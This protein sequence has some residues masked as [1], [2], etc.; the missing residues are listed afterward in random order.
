MMIPINNTSPAEIQR[1]IAV[2]VNQIVKD[3]NRMPWHEFLGDMLKDLEQMHARYFASEMAPSGEPWR[4]LS[5][6]T[7]AKK[8]FDRILHDSGRLYNSLGQRGPGAIRRVRH[9][10]LVFGTS[11]PYAKYHMTGFRNVRSN[12]QVPARP[13]LGVTGGDVRELSE[14][15]AEAIVRKL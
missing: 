1:G 7:I 2:A 14:K 3:V 5:P 4:S 10:E 12:T 11:V 13:F 15:L 9:R 8:G 6:Y